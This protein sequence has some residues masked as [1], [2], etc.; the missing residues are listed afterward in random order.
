MGKV[1]H[2]NIAAFKW[3]FTYFM[4]DAEKK[5]LKEKPE[6]P[7]PPKAIDL[8]VAERV[9]I[10]KEEIKMREMMEQEKLKNI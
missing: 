2:E 4:N 8:S 1:N 10:T 9:I 3:D 7:V 5:A 6:I